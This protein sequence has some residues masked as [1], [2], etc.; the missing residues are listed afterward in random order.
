MPVIITT[1][2]IVTITIDIIIM[3]ITII[4]IIISIIIMPS[5]EVLRVF[6]SGHMTEGHTARRQQWLRAPEE[7]ADVRASMPPFNNKTQMSIPDAVK[8]IN[9]P[10][11]G[12]CIA[13]AV[14]RVF[15]SKQLQRIAL[16]HHV[17]LPRYRL[18]SVVQQKMSKVHDLIQHC[19]R[20]KEIV[21]RNKNAIDYLE[22]FVNDFKVLEQTSI[23]NLEEWEAFI[24]SHVPCGWEANLH[25]DNILGNFGFDKTSSDTLQKT[26]FKKPDGEETTFEQHSFRWLSKAFSGYG[27]AGALSDVVNLVFAMTGDPYVGLSDID[28]ACKI[29]AFNEKIMANDY[30]HFWIPTHFFMDAEVDDCLVWVLLE[31]VR[32]ATNSEFNVLVQLP[33]EREFDK[34]ADIWKSVPN[35]EVWRD[36]NSRNSDALKDTYELR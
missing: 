15:S 11:F 14:G 23:N 4:S 35:C 17:P 19:R 18:S 34:V 26:I 3:S 13:R 29:D 6:W 8:K 32:E 12:P 30:G 28:I 5:C 31:R 9:V 2:I 16:R 27:L 22:A 24:G 25:F 20:T 21:E 10:S 33:A 7:E 1:T 36:L